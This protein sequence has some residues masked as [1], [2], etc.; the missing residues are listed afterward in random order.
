MSRVHAKTL[1]F[2]GAIVF[3]VAG[4]VGCSSTGGTS[5]NL[6]EVPRCTILKS[7][8]AENP[9]V[10]GASASERTDPSTT[11]GFTRFRNIS[12]P[13]GNPA[14]GFTPDVYGISEAWTRNSTGSVVVR[15]QSHPA[16]R[17]TTGPFSASAWTLNAQDARGAWSAPIRTLS[18]Q[19][20]NEV[21]TPTAGSLT[22]P[23][24]MPVGVANP[25]V[26]G[27]AGLRSQDEAV[28]STWLIEVTT[29]NPAA[30][31][32]AGVDL[33]QD[34][35]NGDDRFVP[36]APGILIGPANPP[37]PRII[38]RPGNPVSD[39]S[40]KCAMMQFQD[41]VASRELHMLAIRNGVLYHSMASNFGL[42]TAS[43]GSG[44]PFNRFNTVSTWGDVGQ[45]LGGGFGNIVDATMVARPNAV[46]VFFVAES[47][48]TYK[49]WHAVRFSSSG[50]SWRAADDVFGKIGIYPRGRLDRF[51]V[52]AGLCPTLENPY[53]SELVYA[54][55][56]GEDELKIGRVVSTP[57]HWA[58]GVDG[59]YSHLFGLSHLTGGTSDTSRLSRI[60]NIQILARPFSDISR[61]S[62]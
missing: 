42:T 14:V 51:R 20:G 29:A 58:A 47:G 38:G 15:A 28:R 31:T 62:P 37:S 44:S 43:S 39:G 12:E 26:F 61:A 1:L 21:D 13:R 17:G 60:E 57:R 4:L 10:N 30:G 16:R 48:G 19:R 11:H 41:N 53:T 54:M 45:A 35:L 9:V 32:S 40:V 34:M 27:C 49:L 56:I 6:A 22:T 24:L 3:S 36:N 18:A 23:Q 7:H 33:I 59:I 8:F 25:Q 5:P 55:W 52:A 2:Q 46:S 50:G